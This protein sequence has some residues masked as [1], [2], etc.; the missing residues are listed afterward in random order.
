MKKLFLLFILFFFSFLSGFSQN[1][2]KADTSI[3]SQHHITNGELSGIVLDF[4]SKEPLLYTNIYVLHKN[5]GTVTNENGRFAIDVL[6]LNK[7]DTLRFQYIG[8]K[9]RN[10]TIQML[11]TMSA[12][13]LKKES[14]NL[15]EAVIFGGSTPDPRTI[16]KNIIRNKDSNYR[17]KPSLWKT[18]IRERNTADVTHFRIDYKKSSI[19]NLDRQAIAEME[20]K[21]PKH[22]TAYTD[23]LG[24]LYFSG[25]NKDTL[26]I[27][28]IRTV[29][30][31]EKNMADL[32]QIEDIFDNLAANTSE[33]EYWKMRSGIVGGKIDFSENDTTSRNDSLHKNQQ[34][35]RYYRRAVFSEMKYPSLDDKKDWEFLYKTGKYKYT[36][37]GGIRVNGEDIYIIDFEPDNGGI[38]KGRLFVS[39]STYALIRA[40]YEYAPGKEGTDFHLFGVGYSENYFS[41]SIYFEKVNGSYVL[42]YFSQKTGTA[43]DF[44]RNIILLKKR[45]RFLFDKT[46]KELKVGLKIA[47][48]SESSVEMLVL[49]RK[50]IPQKA[51]D[52]FQQKKYMNII[53]VDQF[54]DS[55]WKGYS[56]IEPTRQMKE[57]KKA[58]HPR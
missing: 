2:E 36:L 9:A 18:F 10:L 24:N 25:N 46:L 50:Q 48:N 45:K 42:K 14:Y 20:Q 53:Y 30:L 52:D 16:V 11:D 32:K 1:Q 37:A 21:L 6:G 38:F 7:N 47:V 39:A 22:T 5:I 4:N 56:I 26:K 35:L 44:D 28:P 49:D 23:F 17:T 43:V 3:V 33:N 41:G 57:Y 40:D 51:F 58:A 19:E 54:N 55:L 13:Y 12:V 15:L 34:K 8:Y 31:K 29:E 27:A